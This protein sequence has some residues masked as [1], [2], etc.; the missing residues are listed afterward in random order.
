MIR[1]VEGL[2]QIEEELGCKVLARLIV[3]SK[4][5][6]VLHP[7]SSQVKLAFERVI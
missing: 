6:G 3:P 4:Q 2:W 7:E 5:A 1:R